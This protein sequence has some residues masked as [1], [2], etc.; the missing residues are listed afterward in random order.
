ML[1][2]QFTSGSDARAW[3]GVGGFVRS[4]SDH[5]CSGT[6]KEATLAFTGTTAHIE[7]REKAVMWPAPANDECDTDALTVHAAGAACTALVTIDATLAA[8]P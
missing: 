5:V 2:W 3:T 6:A 7:S 8:D 4:A 1:G